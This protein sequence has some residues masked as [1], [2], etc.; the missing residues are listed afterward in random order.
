MP[1]R[2]LRL[3]TPGT[4]SHLRRQVVRMATAGIS[5]NA[6]AHRLQLRRATIS[7]W[8]KH[9][10]QQ[11]QESLSRVVRGRP[12]APSPP[13]EQLLRLLLPLPTAPC[14]WTTHTAA[15]EV[16]RHLQVAP[17]TRTFRK[18]LMQTGL[19]PKPEGIWTAAPQVQGALARTPQLQPF[20]AAATPWAGAMKGWAFSLFDTTGRQA[21]LLCDGPL[22][23][24]RWIEFLERARKHIGNRAALMLMQPEWLCQ[25]ASVRRWQ[26]SHQS[27]IAVIGIAPFTA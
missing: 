27:Q 9:F 25:R 7:A 10:R 15:Q 19:L 23:L 17:S 6:I 18:I 13:A 20:L 1:S 26:D 22:R 8:L 4:V 12:A 16:A 21:F 2:D 14:L 11:G 5:R 24:A 3:C